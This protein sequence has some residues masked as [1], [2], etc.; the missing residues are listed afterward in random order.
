[1]E[2]G[3]L[4]EGSASRDGCTSFITIPRVSEEF[5]VKTSENFIAS[6]T[7]W[8]VTGHDLSRRRQ[9]QTS[10]CVLRFYHAKKRRPYRDCPWY[11]GNR[12]VS[13][14]SGITTV[15]LRSR[16]SQAVVRGD[17]LLFVQNFRTVQTRRSTHRVEKPGNN[18]GLSGPFLPRQTL[19]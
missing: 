16:I 3:C 1:M 18:G 12:Q 13:C 15:N 4:S 17:L 8:V 14:G 2:A 10:L 19:P 5:G 6:L 9:T 11:N 7:H